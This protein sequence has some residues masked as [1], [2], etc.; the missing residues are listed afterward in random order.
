MLVLLALPARA[1]AAV[2]TF[3]AER[4]E[5]FQVKL[6]GETINFTATNFVRIAPVRVGRHYVEFKIRSRH[7]VYQMGQN[8]YVPAGVEANYGVRTV[9]RSG[10][11]YLRLISEVPLL[12]PPSPVVM[13][14]PSYPRYPDYEQDRYE[15]VP[16]RY[17]DR[18]SDNCRNL[19]S[20]REL[21]RLIQTMN[22]RSFESTKLSIAREALRN[23][24]ILADDLKRLLQQFEYESTRL[25]FAKYAYDYLC[26]R[27]HFYYI[28]DLFRY[29]SNVRELEEYAARRR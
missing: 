5:A 10:K 15:P 12:P 11:S 3:T 27:E 28:F 24:S 18:Y 7:G 8:V 13:P 21:D 19:L 1:Q 9:G 23:G 26:D 16:P 14:S 17:E 2:L 25:E 20:S 4:G 29:D 22:S 6:D